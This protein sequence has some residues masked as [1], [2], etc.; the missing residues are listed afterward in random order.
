MRQMYNFVGLVDCL[1]RRAFIYICL[2]IVTMHMAH[3]A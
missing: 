2:D 1:F 3:V